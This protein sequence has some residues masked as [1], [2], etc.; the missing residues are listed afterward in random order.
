ML[1]S[2][3]SSAILSV[4]A[5]LGAIF[6]WRKK[7]QGGIRQLICEITGTDNDVVNHMKTALVCMM[8]EDIRQLCEKCLKE[9]NITSEELES[10]ICMYES[11][12]S[13]GGN[14]FVHSL[15]AK[16]KMLPIDLRE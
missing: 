3:V 4:T 10:L 5:L 7:A 8:R 13:L 9:Q 1:A 14:S 11:Y 2:G 6:V 15:V 16:V 12:K